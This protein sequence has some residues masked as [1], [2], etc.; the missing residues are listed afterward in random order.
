MDLITA[1][2][3]IDPAVPI[4]QEHVNTEAVRPQAKRQRA[5][6]AGA[7]RG[8]VDN[9]SQKKSTGTSTF[10]QMPVETHAAYGQD[11]YTISDDSDAPSVDG[12]REVTEVAGPIRL[13][14]WYFQILIQPVETRHQT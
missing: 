10:D 6:T 12:A 5:D 2:L 7:S 14:L 13:S 9:T 4:E 3:D 11:A 1:V 8:P